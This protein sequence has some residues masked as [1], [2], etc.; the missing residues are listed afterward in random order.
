MP[1]PSYTPGDYLAGTQGLLPSGPVWPRDADAVLTRV[2]G[3]FAVT[4]ARTGNRGVALVTDAFPAT[5]QE[6][7]PEWEATLGLPDPCSG[8]LP[9]VQQR[10]AA[11]VERLTSRGGQSV[12]YFVGVAARL[13][14]AV[15]ITEYVPSTAGRMRAGQR[16]HGKEWAHAWRMNA[17]VVPVT[18]FRAGLSVAGER[19]S[20][21]GNKPLEC[22]IGRYAP[23]HTVVA[24]AYGATG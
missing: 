9:T 1:L 12:P 13:G 2:L 23:A 18:R 21:F 10:R 5:T 8:P 7:L 11:V 6:L 14:Y 17:P 15:T 19:L 4:Y 20:S 24:F 22:T 3:A 16:L